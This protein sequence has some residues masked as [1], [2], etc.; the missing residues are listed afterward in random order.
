MYVGRKCYNRR[1]MTRG[2]VVSESEDFITILIDGVRR[3]VTPSMFEKWWVLLK[4]TDEGEKKEAVKRGP[5][6][7][8]DRDRE[9]LK[10][11]SLGKAILYRFI[12]VVKEYT[13][14]DFIT[15]Y[16]KDGKTITVKFNG[17]VVFIL[18]LKVK[19][20]VVFAHPNS[21][22]PQCVSRT[23]RVYPQS[24]HKS[25]RARFDI[26]SLEQLGLMKAVVSDG[27]FYR[28]H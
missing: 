14:G 7:Y 3:S 11:K 20:L 15:A 26:E 4:E 13:D 17:Y 8:S 23:T 25:L 10:E 9:H 22:T 1:N 19:K 6:E 27:I 12:E 21:L 2:E 5:V 16:S 24:W 18:S 28:K